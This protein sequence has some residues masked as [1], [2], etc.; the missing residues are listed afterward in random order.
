MERQK[1]TENDRK[2]NRYPTQ[3]E[4]TFHVQHHPGVRKTSLGSSSKLGT[5]GIW[6]GA[7]DRTGNEAL[8]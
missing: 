1:T 6:T 5:G 3:T 4:T 2:P 7:G 8:T